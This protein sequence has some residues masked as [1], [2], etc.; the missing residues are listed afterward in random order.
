MT[1]YALVRDLS[2]PNLSTEAFAAA[3]G[4]HPQLVAHLIGLG[5]LDAYPGPGGSV[6]LPPAQVARA[7][8]IVRLRQGLGL[9]YS[10]VA[11]VLDLLDRIDELEAALR[12]RPNGHRR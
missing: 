3:T 12:G 6:L 11:L 8:R 9:N 10:A 5:L 4:L 1:R 2:A 7:A